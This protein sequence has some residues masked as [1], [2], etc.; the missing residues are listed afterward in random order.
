MSELQP[1]RERS[2]L[3][4]IFLSPDEPRLRAGWRL[5]I[6]TLLMFVFGTIFGGIAILLGLLDLGSLAGQILNF[7]IITVSVYVA[8]RWLD[9][10]SFESLG[11][12][13]DR[14][15]PISW[16]GLA[17]PSSKWD[18]SMSLCLLSAG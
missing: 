16:Q 12:K 6:Q 10:R 11:L 17:S 1:R 4:T 9:K 5:I 13:L 7:L 14:H 15:T 18:L 2:F 8:R 3:A